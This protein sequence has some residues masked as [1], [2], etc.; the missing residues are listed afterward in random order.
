MCICRVCVFD[1]YHQYYHICHHHIV[2]AKVCG[3]SCWRRWPRRSWWEDICLQ[4]NLFVVD[5]APLSQT[6]KNS[7]KRWPSP[8]ND[9]VVS[10]KLFQGPFIPLLWILFGQTGY[11][12]KFFTYKWKSTD[13]LFF[14]YFWHQI[15]PLS[16]IWGHFF[17]FQRVCPIKFS[18]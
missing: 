9:L 17:T 16:S 2:V 4:V 15:Q 10:N 11:P 1:D 13:F 5:D 8:R 18:K 7:F 6:P 14:S 12:I 3:Q